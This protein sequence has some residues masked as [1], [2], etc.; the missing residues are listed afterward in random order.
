MR[1]LSVWRSQAACCARWKL[2]S[3]EREFFNM[4]IKV[5]ILIVTVTPLE[6]QAIVQ[7]F[8][9]HTKEVTK[10]TRINDHIYQ[11]LGTVNNANVFMA[12]SE[13]GAGGDGGS[14][15]SVR[16]SIEALKP[17]TVTMVGIAFGIN[18]QTQKIGDLLVSQQLWLYEL[19]RVGAENTIS[20]GDKVHAS[21]RLINWFQNSVLHWQGAEI[22]LGLVMTGEKLV[23][24]VDY[25]D[26][27]KK[28]EPEAIGGEMEGEGLYAACQNSGVDWILV[29]GICDWADGIK[30]Q[31]KTQRVLFSIPSN[32]RLSIQQESGE[33]RK[34]HRYLVR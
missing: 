10:P 8:K 12:I 29:K 23:D 33:E 19:Q 6:S 2:N 11:N 13:M 15:E 16:K 4:P 26:Q 31:D 21:P 18:E 25:R 20:R 3:P 30:G 1:T 32:K 7:A 5:D 9:E 27:L 34:E 22:H 17:P 24:N 14:Q 28:F